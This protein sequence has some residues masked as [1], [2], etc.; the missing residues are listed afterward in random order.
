MIHCVQCDDPFERASTR[1]RAPVYCSAACRQRA[2]LLRTGATDR[3]VLEL[4]AEWARSDA[5]FRDA[6]YGT[7][8]NVARKNAA[9]VLDL[10]LAALRDRHLATTNPTKETP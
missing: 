7:V 2:Y 9:T 6:P 8:K 5:R 10:L 3:K 4:G 1:G